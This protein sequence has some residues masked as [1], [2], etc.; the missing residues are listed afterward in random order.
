MSVSFSIV[1]GGVLAASLLQ[2]ATGFGFALVATPIFH[3]VLSR[4]AAVAPVLVGQTVNLL[5][6]FGERRRPRVEWPAVRVALCAALHGL[7]VAA[8]IR[9]V[10]AQILQIAV[11]AAVCVIAASNIVRFPH[12]SPAPKTGLA[13]P[14]ASSAT[15]MVQATTA[16]GVSATITRLG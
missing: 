3:T 11:G 6:L 13:K 1:S 2:T 8:V 10:P 4:P 14:A 9:A 7:V 15:N 12:S 16:R 5:V